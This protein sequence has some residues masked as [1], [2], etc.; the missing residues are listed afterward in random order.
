M[1]KNNSKNIE[2]VKKVYIKTFGCQMNEYDSEKMVEVLKKENYSITNHSIEAD[3]II[4]NTCSIREKAENKVYSELGRLRKLKSYNPNLKIGVGG[5]VAQ[6]EKTSI[7]RRST[8][9]DFVFGTDNLFDLPEIIKKITSGQKICQTKRHPRQKIRNFIPDYTFKKTK[10]FGIKSFLA[11]TKGCNNNCSFCVVPSTRGGEVSREP[12]NIIAE[13]KNLISS[14]SKEICL[15]GQNVNSYNAKDTNFVELLKNLDSLKNMERLRFISPHP[16]DFNNDLADAF[17]NLK[18]LC[19]HMHL[20]LQSGSNR[21]LNRM[22]RWYTMETFY[23]KVNLLRDRIPTATL[24]TDL[25]VGF[26]GE[27]DE[28]FEMTMEA[29]RKV[30]FDSI[31]SFKY[32]PRPGTQAI[33]Y[34]EQISENIKSQRLKKLIET[35]EKIILEKNNILIGSVQE[36][37]IERENNNLEKTL[38]GR[39]RGNHMVNIENCDANVGE[40]VQVKIIGT[41]KNSLIAKP[42]SNNVF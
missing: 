23:E 36:I 27:T 38:S 30:R 3:L 15:L 29:V 10:S 6:Q 5:C 35:Q 31:F 34:T 13:A 22:R 32:S 37:L 41:N 8:S 18:S 20:P 26:P 4:L 28:E 2:H 14:G 7:L 17:V 1:E 24:S 21:I 16:K 19:E 40:L 42:L 25:I 33:K 39:T 9:V 11:I 12:E